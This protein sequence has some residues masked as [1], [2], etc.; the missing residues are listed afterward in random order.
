MR[1]NRR[2]GRRSTSVMQRNGVDARKQCHVRPMVHVPVWFLRSAIVLRPFAW[3]ANVTHFPLCLGLLP[4][5]PMSHIFY[6]DLCSFNCFC[7]R[8][9]SC[10][11]FVSLLYLLGPPL[12][13]LL[14]VSPSVPSLS[15]P[16]I[17]WILPCVPRCLFPLLNV[18]PCL[19]SFVFEP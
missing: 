16:C 15:L 14:L 8:L 6:F 7:A 9:P 12:C 17:S 2:A 1:G 18:A 13:P 19:I 4:G 11:L 5:L 3:F 10:A